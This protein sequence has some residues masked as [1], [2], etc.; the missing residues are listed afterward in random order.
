[1]STT[2]AIRLQISYNVR[3]DTKHHLARWVMNRHSFSD[4]TSVSR[5]GKQCLQDGIKHLA[6][7]IGFRATRLISADLSMGMV[8]VKIW[9]PAPSIS[10]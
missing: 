1:M 9:F 2:P 10:G 4:L 6:A 3:D 8:L 7:V 5:N